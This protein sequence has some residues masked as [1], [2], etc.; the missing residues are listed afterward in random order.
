MIMMTMM[1]IDIY[2]AHDYV[3]TEDNFPPDSGNEDCVKR[4]DNDICFLAGDDRV[5]EQPALTLMHTLFLRY[6]YILARTLRRTWP[7]MKDELV[8]QQARAIVWAVMQNI[9]YSEWLPILLSPSAREQH[10]L[11]LKE[12]KFTRNNSEM[13]PSIFSAFSSAVFRWVQTYCRLEESN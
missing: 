13:D 12:G 6:H 8:F 1:M 7:G 11:D 5:N 2:D 3:T 9:L 4:D 10:G